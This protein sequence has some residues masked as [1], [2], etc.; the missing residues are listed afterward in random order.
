MYVCKCKYKS[1]YLP[2]YFVSM[3]HIIFGEMPL[4]FIQHIFSVDLYMSEKLFLAVSIWGRSFSTV[5]IS[6]ILAISI[7]RT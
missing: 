5:R 2:P 1:P 7:L 4:K 6:I 3:N